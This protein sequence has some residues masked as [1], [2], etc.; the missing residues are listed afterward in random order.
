M[1]S[2]GWTLVAISHI[3]F[4]LGLTEKAIVE[5]ILGEGKIQMSH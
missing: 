3:R 2:K 4:T 5:G 1:W